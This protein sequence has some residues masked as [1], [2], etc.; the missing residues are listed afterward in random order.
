MRTAIATRTPTCSRVVR[1]SPIESL[2]RLLISVLP[3]RVA[4]VGGFG[5]VV[6][7]PGAPAGIVC[8][9]GA[10]PGR[11]GGCRRGAGGD[12]PVAA[13]PLHAVALRAETGNAPCRGRWC[14]LEWIPV[15]A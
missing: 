9:L 3:F 15:G 2:I 1:D 4:G 6:G 5:G 12:H 10:G 13:D 14:K 8:L 11:G 7:G